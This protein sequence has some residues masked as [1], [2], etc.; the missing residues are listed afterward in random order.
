MPRNRITVHY[1]A[2]S[3]I[4]IL[5][6]RIV[7]NNHDVREPAN[8]SEW[9]PATIIN[10]SYTS[11]VLQAWA[12]ESFQQTLRTMV[13]EFYYNSDGLDD[14]QGDFLGL[15]Q[16][17]LKKRNAKKA[18]QGVMAFRMRSARRDGSKGNRQRNTNSDL[19]NQESQDRVKMW[20]H[21]QE[22]PTSSDSE[23]AVNEKKS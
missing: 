17:R 5:L 12:P 11:A 9:P 3:R 19:P 2:D 16:E 14:E 1:I 20:L 10:S 21:S 8:T 18:L 15:S 4:G 13:K 6:P 22:V 7:P 23:R